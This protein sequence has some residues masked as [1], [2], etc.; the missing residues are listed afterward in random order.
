MM[1]SKFLSKFSPKSSANSGQIGTNKWTKNGSKISPR[2]AT[3]GP[4]IFT[5]KGPKGARMVPK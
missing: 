1:Q 3:N 5:Q 2:S 4:Y